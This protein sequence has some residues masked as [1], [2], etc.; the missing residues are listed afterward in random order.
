MQRLACAALA[1][2]LAATPGCRK[3]RTSEIGGMSDTTLSP[4]AAPAPEPRDTAPAVREFGLDQRQEFVQ[5]IRQQLAGI[6]RQIKELSDQAKSRGGAVSDRALANIRA[7]RRAVDRNLKRTE[8]A[9]A[10][11]WEQVKRGV[12]Q[13]VDNLTESI[14]GAQPK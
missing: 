1:L 10:A 4:A 6:D 2:L 11:N 9:T 12:Y 7:S 13:S 14:E 5:S 8:A 3:K